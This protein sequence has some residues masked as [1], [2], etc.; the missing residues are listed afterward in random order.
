MK[1]DEVMAAYLESVRS[2]DAVA[3]MAVNRVTR[4]SPDKITGAP[5]F[6]FGAINEPNSPKYWGKKVYDS[7]W[8]DWND[9]RLTFRLPYPEMYCFFHYRGI[10]PTY[11]LYHL[12]QD[13]DAT[14]HVETWS[15]QPELLGH[16]AKWTRQPCVISFN[17]DNP[18]EY[19]LDWPFNPEKQDEYWVGECEE[20]AKSNLSVSVA[21]IGL[22][23]RSGTTVREDDL[24]DTVVKT[25]AKRERVSLDPVTKPIVVRMVDREAVLNGKRVVSTLTQKSPHDR[26]GHW[27]KF[28]DGRKVWVRSCKIHGGRNDPATYV[29]KG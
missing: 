23:N 27:R 15:W 8:N 11:N 22:L 13:D 6:D 2:G 9:E 3:L 18:D 29:V 12:I 28:R 7:L 1:S 17:P 25:N 14:I 4:I 21:A 20:D 26:R 10:V 19:G 24:S 16:Q 5:L